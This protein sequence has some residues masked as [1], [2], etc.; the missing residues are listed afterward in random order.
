MNARIDQL[1][2]EARLLAS[3]DRSLLALALLDSLQGEQADE[4][5]V[6]RA[7]IS[8]ARCRAQLLRDG[9]G[10]T[11]PWVEARARISAL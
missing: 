5:A 1:F 3:E 4:A 10:K 9:L 8:E 11:V 2:D 6:E 7:W